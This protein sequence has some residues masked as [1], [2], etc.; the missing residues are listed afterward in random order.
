MKT[1]AWPIPNLDSQHIRRALTHPLPGLSAQLRMA[2][3]GRP[4]ERPA[5]GPLPRAAAVLVLLYSQPQGRSLRII[6]TRRTERLGHHS[7]QVSFPGGRREPGDVDFVA[8][9]LR[10]T[11][12]ELG[13]PTDA[14]EVLGALTGLYVSPSNFDIHPMVGYLAERPICQPNPDEVAEVIEPTLAELFDPTAKGQTERILL[15]QGGQRL[16]TPC[17]RV[18]NAEIWGAT[19]MIL[20]ELETILGKYEV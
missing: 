9:A 19:A 14:L 8:T 11:R 1:A 3:P 18:G 15:S 20:S 17:Y 5:D 7:G 2:P 16:P 13:I 6:L 4:T 10:E 12:E